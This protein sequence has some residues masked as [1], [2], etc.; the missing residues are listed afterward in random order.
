MIDLDNIDRNQAIK[1]CKLL[2][3]LIGISEVSKIINTFIKAFFDKSIHKDD[4][5]D[6]LHGNYNL[7]GTISGRLSSSQP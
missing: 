4:G 3:N 2:K 7:N 1:I 5:M 6:Y